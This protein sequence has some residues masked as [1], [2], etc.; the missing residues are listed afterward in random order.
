MCVHVH[1]ICY[2][3]NTWKTNSQLAKESEIFEQQHQQEK[4]LDIFPNKSF[5]QNTN[6]PY[7]N[8]IFSLKT[9][10]QKFPVKK[11]NMGKKMVE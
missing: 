10:L 2:V 8:R 6:F 11:D 5:N 3:T 7:H 4:Q 9:F 1:L